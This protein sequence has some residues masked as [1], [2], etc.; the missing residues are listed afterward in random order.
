ML[1]KV[2]NHFV[3][4]SFLLPLHGSGG[5]NSGDQAYMARLLPTELPAS[6]LGTQL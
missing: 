5:S 6:L 4:G 1:G 2:R 3:V